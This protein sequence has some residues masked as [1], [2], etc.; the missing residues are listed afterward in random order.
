M[1]AKSRIKFAPKRCNWHG[2]WLGIIV[3]A[4]GGRHRLAVDDQRRP[5][6]FS[7]HGYVVAQRPLDMD[8]AVFRDGMP[9]IHKIRSRQGHSVH[10]HYSLYGRCGGPDICKC[11]S[12]GC[13][14][15]A[16]VVGRRCRGAF[17][18]SGAGL[19]RRT[20]RLS[21]VPCGQH[22]GICRFSFS[23]FQEPAVCSCHGGVVAG[24]IVF[25]NIPRGALSRRC[26][27]RLSRRKLV[28]M[29]FLCTDEG[30]VVCQRA[31]RRMNGAQNAGEA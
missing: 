5:L 10:N 9:D 12:A 23:D 18:S 8:S 24:Y 20:V 6:R 15:P 16:A 1:S 30:A 27:C 22:H 7:R 14:T 17:P 3:V 21:V 2:L 13:R 29:P 31:S 26:A 28:R 4:L 25:Q 11:H 19:L